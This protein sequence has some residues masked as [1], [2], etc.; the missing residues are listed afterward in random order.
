MLIP[1]SLFRRSNFIMKNHKDKRGSI[2]DQN[3]NLNPDPSK[4]TDLRSTIVFYKGSSCLPMFNSYVKG[5]MEFK[6][7]PLKSLYLGIVKYLI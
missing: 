1:K 5:L 2:L 4:S 7:L 6:F 3:I